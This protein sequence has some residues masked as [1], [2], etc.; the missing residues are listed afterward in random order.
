MQSGLSHSDLV[1]LLSGSFG[2]DLLD[3][4]G[5]GASGALPAHPSTAQEV[6]DVRAVLQ[7]TGSARLFGVSSGAMVAAR[8]ALV[9]RTIERL[10]LFEP[11]L[12]VGGSRQAD[13]TNDVTSALDRDD[14]PRAMGIAMKATEMGPPWMFGLP[15]LF[16][17]S[18]LA[19][20]CVRTTSGDWRERCVRISR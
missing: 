13:L 4:R 2:V 11:P 20:S 6:D 18:H 3:R 16:S 7:S 19:P 14:L 12:F 1:K 5:R 10:G 15:V 9:D 17:R 8:V